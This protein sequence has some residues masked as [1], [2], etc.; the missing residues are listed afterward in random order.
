MIWFHQLVFIAFS[1]AG[2]RTAPRRHRNGISS[3]GGPTTRS[4]DFIS[5]ALTLISGGSLSLSKTHG[6]WGASLMASA[7]KVIHCWVIGYHFRVIR[8]RAHSAFLSQTEFDAVSPACPNLLRCAAVPISFCQVFVRY[9][10]LLLSVIK[11]PS[12]K[13]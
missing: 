2:A 5:F 6:S 13:L 10:T 3:P 4:A 1:G 8:R 7:P 9:R 11:P 12:P